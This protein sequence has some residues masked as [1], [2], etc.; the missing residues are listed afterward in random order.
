[1]LGRRDGVETLQ[2]LSA[3]VLAAE[4]TREA[5]EFEG[6]WYTWGDLA[7]VAG[8]VQA[9]L[10]AAG[11][12]P[13]GPVALISRNHPAVVAALLGLIAQGRTIRMIYAFQSPAGIAREREVA[14]RTTDPDRPGPSSS[15]A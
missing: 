9:L 13:D 12:A 11:I 5:L 15:R 1:M 4:P 8:R 10:D 7:A 14:L 2:E 3:K 6:R